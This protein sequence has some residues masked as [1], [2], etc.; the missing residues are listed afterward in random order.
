MDINILKD[1]AS[2]SFLASSYKDSYKYSALIIEND[3]TQ[4][5]AWLIKGL[6][7]A[8]MMVDDDTIKV[9]EALFSLDRG[10]QNHTP[11]FGIEKTQSLIEK[12][13]ADII[14]SLEASHKEKIV[15]HHKIPMPPGG[16]VVLHR[17]AQ[18]GFG[19]LS[20]KSFVPKRIAAIKLLE[21]SL[22]LNESEASLKFIL[23][24]VN[25]FYSH[26][27]EY[28]DYLKDEPEATNYL[29]KLRA[30]LISKAK[31]ADIEVNTAPPAK[32]GCFIAT[33]STGSYDHP[34]VLVLRLFRDEILQHHKL[35]QKLIA[36]Y[37]RVS[38]PIASKIEHSEMRKK[39][40]LK[41]FI[42]PLAMLATWIIKA[43]E[44]AKKRQ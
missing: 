42:N 20:A 37:Y 39:L 23:S 1:L 4:S 43:K 41:T 38:P 6:S 36:Y 33:A 2:S 26:S 17:L 29:A 9:E 30:S 8:A 24:A 10:F 14:K 32:S 13:Y 27:A 16:S 19:R 5:E 18:K 44:A 34:K 12:C 21:K 25:T 22:S 7:A 3:P 35:G 28:M 11:S 31:A 40:V 15:D